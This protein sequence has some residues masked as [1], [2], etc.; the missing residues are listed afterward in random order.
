MSAAMSSAVAE[1]ATLA[2]QSDGRRRP[3]AH[4][5]HGPMPGGWIR[6]QSA[7]ENVLRGDDFQS[8]VCS[9]KIRRCVYDYGRWDAEL[10]REWEGKATGGRPATASALEHLKVS[11]ARAGSS[12]RTTSGSGWRRAAERCND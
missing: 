4:G 1:K 10:Q 6:L 5:K 3:S 9:I 2:S 8:F 7:T 11:G 12:V